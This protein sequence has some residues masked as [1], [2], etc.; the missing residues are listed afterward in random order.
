MKGK[1]VRAALL[2]CGMGLFLFA[3]AVTAV[4]VL[5]FPF[6]RAC[7]G[8]GAP[9]QL[10][11]F[12]A[13]LCAFIALG[14]MLRRIPQARLSR[15]ARI[16]RP[17]FLIL[18]FALH[19]LLGVL[20]AYTPSGDNAM[21]IGAS[22]MLAKT[23]SLDG[24]PDYGLY[25]SRFSNQWG[26]LLILSALFKLFFALGFGEALFPLVALQAA[27]IAAGLW[28]AL[29]IARDLGGARGEI[30]M[31]ASL[32]CLMPLYLAAAVLYTD[33]F[34][35]PFV[36]LTLRF[37][38]A[39]PRAK[40]ARARVGNA[41]LSA[42]FAVIGAQIKMTVL[43]ALL[44]SCIV[45]LL[46]LRPRQA[47]T[48]VGLCAGIV[49]AALLGVKGFMLGRVL[50]PAVYAQEHT[51]AIHWVMM[52]IPTGDNP[53]GGYSGGD[54]AITWGMM[55]EGA[56]REEV[57]ASILAR[58]RDR[59]YTLRYP[60]RLITA[61]LR[62]NT[63]ALGDGTFGM[64]EMLDDGPVRENVVSSFVLEG[65]AHYALYGALCTGVFMVH[66]ALSA[67]G[68]LIDLR[69]RDPRAATLAI[70]M[71]GMMLFL[72]LWEARGR[73]VFTFVP[74]L[75]LLSVRGQASVAE[76]LD[77]RRDSDALARHAAGASAPGYGADDPVLPV[78]GG[79]CADRAV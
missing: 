68:C 75:L 78:H 5:L 42:L 3:A 76:A 2:R 23:G 60:N 40:E 32:A 15:I 55:D 50:D 46:S 28:A 49:I 22:R 18:L 17:A 21:L 4:N 14:H 74:V 10:A 44:A 30:A 63:A 64:T 67:A 59:V 37:A 62:K 41:L 53:Y 36:L 1:N 77:Q 13:S 43:I 39:V 58:M 61:A 51:P 19:L 38:L 52:S 70:A 12:A 7:Y 65:R 57:M 31:L 54:Y 35:M 47:L 29:S 33:T 56:T 11:A 45:W 6:A 20:M 27:L 66:M 79:Q 9:G 25:L 34:S 8:Y 16:A 71:F 48:A 26:F 69:R 72:M 73:Y 24:N